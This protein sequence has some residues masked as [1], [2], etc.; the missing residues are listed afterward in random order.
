MLDH[1][2]VDLVPEAVSEAEWTRRVAAGDYQ[3]TGFHSL[4]SGDLSL[5]LAAYQAEVPE[6]APMLADRL[7]EAAAVLVA[8]MTRVWLVEPALAVLRDRR[9][10]LPGGVFSDFAAARLSCAPDRS[11][12]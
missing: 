1:V 3:V 12:L 4:Q 6:V 11:S 2:G 9:L 8:A 7:A 5:D 10:S